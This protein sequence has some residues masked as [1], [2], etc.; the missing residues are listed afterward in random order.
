MGEQTPDMNPIETLWAIIK[1]KLRQKSF[2]NKIELI[3]GILD[4][5]VRDNDVS[6][7][8]DG[9]CKKLIEGMPERVGALVK[10]RGSHTKF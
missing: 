4:T 6:R 8:L 7:S 3:N 10:A 2:K 9:T 1:K 5:C